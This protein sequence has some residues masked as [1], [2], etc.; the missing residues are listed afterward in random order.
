MKTHHYKY[1]FTG[2]FLFFLAFV[3]MFSFVKDSV[4]AQKAPFAAEL[5]TEYQLDPVFQNLEEFSTLPLQE[6]NIKKGRK[7]PFTDFSKE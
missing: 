6:N 7:N 4:F 5:N 3:A 2:V 1:F